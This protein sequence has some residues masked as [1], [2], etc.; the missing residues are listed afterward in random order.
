MFSAPHENIPVGGLSDK[1]DRRLRRGSGWWSDWRGAL[2]VC[3]GSLF[4]HGVIFLI[5]SLIP[6]DDPPWKKKAVAIVTRLEPELVMVLDEAPVEMPVLE[7]V[8]V[9]EPDVQMESSEERADLEELADV[10]DELAE[11]ALDSDDP[12][13]W[14]LGMEEKAGL[15][16]GFG[17]AEM[18]VNPLS[19]SDGLPTAYKG[20]S[21]AKEKK[22]QI[23][24]HGGAPEVLDAV[25]L[26]LQWLAAHQLPDGSWPLLKGEKPVGKEKNKDKKGSKAEE[27]KGFPEI[28]ASITGTA[29]LAFLGAGHSEHMGQYKQ[30]VQRGVKYLNK[31]LL[32]H[33]G[34]L[35]GKT[36]GASIVLMALAE[37]S[38]FNSSPL[39]VKNANLL[40][41]KLRDTYDGKG[42]GYAG[43]GTDFSVSGW[44]ALGLKS[45]RQADLKALKD[46]EIEI[47]FDKYG[48][49]VNS[50]TDPLT[51]KGFYRPGGKGS[52][53]MSWVGM[54]QKQFLGF[55]KDDPFLKKA[56][57]MSVKKVSGVFKSSSKGLDEYAIYYGTLAAFQ[58]QGPFWKAWNPAMQ[59]AL[60]SLQREGAPEDVGGSWDPGSKHIGK[61]GGRVMTTA[62]FTLCLEVYYRYALMQ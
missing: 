54:F 29:L 17:L 11:E 14:S 41:T 26:A 22:K 21:S 48:V 36:Y 33:P 6:P 34:K 15:P 55:P 27:G 60:L 49:W 24:S 45:G 43:S 51:G 59:E 9:D 46:E 1:L 31:Y 62:I 61:D 12:F 23:K 57:E 25:D 2:S 56:G 32:D 58:Q 35:I 44:V 8:E 10:D 3:T 30:T 4:L 39:T 53:A 42:W 52:L 50:M 20:R 7:E 16:E 37:A 5:V 40:A 13:E 47:L 19:G 28:R 18:A 38:I